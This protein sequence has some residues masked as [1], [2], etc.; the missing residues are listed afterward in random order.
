MRLMSLV[1]SLLITAGCGPAFIHGPIGPQPPSPAVVSAAEEWRL[2]LTKL[3]GASIRSRAAGPCWTSFVA[4]DGL[5]EVR[6]PWP[7]VPEGVEIHR[8]CLDPQWPA[9]LTGAERYIVAC[10]RSKGGV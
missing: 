5:T 2:Q 9:G 3:Y 8:R 6:C 1:L 10:G 4:A 7:F